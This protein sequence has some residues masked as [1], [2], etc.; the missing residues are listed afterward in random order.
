VKPS[1]VPDESERWTTVIVVEGSVTPGFSAVIS[2]LFHL[3]TAPSKMSPI[4]LPLSF[5]PLF[6]PGR[7]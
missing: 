6:T 7:L 1:V 5:N 4:T 3:V 2:G